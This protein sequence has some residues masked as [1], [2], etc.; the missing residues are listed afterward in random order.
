MGSADSPPECSRGEEEEDEEA[1][2]QDRRVGRITNSGKVRVE[3]GGTKRKTRFEYM[4]QSEQRMEKI[5]N[6]D[7]FV[8]IF[9]YFY[10][11]K[12]QNKRGGG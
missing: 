12:F 10:Y 7:L 2:G 11:S 9:F 5:L 4:V 6:V 8:L 3:G 1:V